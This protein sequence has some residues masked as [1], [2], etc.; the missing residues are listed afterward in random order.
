VGDGHLD[1]IASYLRSSRKRAKALEEAG[2][3]ASAEQRLKSLPRS[4]EKPITVAHSIADVMYNAMQELQKNIGFAREKGNTKDE[5]VYLRQASL[6]GLLSRECE[7]IAKKTGGMKGKRREKA[8]REEL[9]KLLSHRVKRHYFVSLNPDFVGYYGERAPKEMREFI[10]VLQR[11]ESAN[12]EYEK[13]MMR[14]KN[15]LGL[16]V[17]EGMAGELAGLLKKAS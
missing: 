4:K 11:A 2:L 6:L 17:D 13:K 12:M 10:G 8:E 9:K 15:L 14:I 3:P 16:L 1:V 5:E 7:R